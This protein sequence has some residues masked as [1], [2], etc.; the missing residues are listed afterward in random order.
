M[1][2]KSL[3]TPVLRRLNDSR[4]TCIFAIPDENIYYKTREELK[5]VPLVDDLDKK[6]TTLARYKKHILIYHHPYYLLVP[7]FEHFVFKNGKVNQLLHTLEVNMHR[8]KLP[9]TGDAPIFNVKF[10]SSRSVIQTFNA[11]V[12]KLKTD[13]GNTE[14]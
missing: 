9:K 1:V 7:I 3:F 2:D 11:I 14:D 10:K 4:N 13:N 6:D 12:V 8:H 5:M